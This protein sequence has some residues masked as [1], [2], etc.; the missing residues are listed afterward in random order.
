MNTD[1][2]SIDSYTLVFRF[3]IDKDIFYSVMN[4]DERNGCFFTQRK[5]IKSVSCLDIT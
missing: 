4:D 3:S 2:K 5:F 1:V